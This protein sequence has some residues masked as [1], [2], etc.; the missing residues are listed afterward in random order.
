VTA[1]P[2][3]VNGRPFSV[4]RSPA[5]TPSP[6]AKVRSSTTPPGR[7]Q[8]PAVSLGWST[9]A[10]ASSRPS[11]SAPAVRPLARIRV[12]ASGKGPLEAVTPGARASFSAWVRACCCSFVPVAGGAEPGGPPVAVGWPR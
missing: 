11:A 7:T 12:P 6:A 1:I 9:V 5:P 2:V 4:I 8:L 10:G 3:T